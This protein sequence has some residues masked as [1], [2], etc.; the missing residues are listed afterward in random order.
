[1]LLKKKNHRKGLVLMINHQKIY[2]YISLINDPSHID[3]VSHKKKKDKNKKNTACNTD[4]N[5]N[6]CLSEKQVAT[7]RKLIVHKCQATVSATYS[8]VKNNRNAGIVAE[9]PVEVS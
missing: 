2:I 8:G 1:M 4:L 6:C 7:Q 9:A 3:T 5:N